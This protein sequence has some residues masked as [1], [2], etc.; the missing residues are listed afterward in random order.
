MK[1]I[2]IFYFMTKC[3]NKIKNAFSDET[4]LLNAN[5][6]VRIP[7]LSTYVVI[8]LCNVRSRIFENYVVTEMGQ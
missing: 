4:P 5:D 3:F 7:L 8:C 1:H 6:G 2:A